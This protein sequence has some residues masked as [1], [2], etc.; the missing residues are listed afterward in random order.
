MEQHYY[1]LPIFFENLITKNKE[2]EPSSKGESIAAHVY[3]IITSKYGES[4]FDETYGC[5]IWDFDFVNIT[6]A[7]NWKSLIVDS[8]VKNIIKHEKRLMNVKVTLDIKEEDVLNSS[9]NVKSVKKAVRI[10]VS[11]NLSDTNEPFTFVQKMFLSP[12]SFE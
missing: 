12:L 11:A 10:S 1:K 4:R 9:T 5:E 6:N 7:S 2:L 3:L 8:V